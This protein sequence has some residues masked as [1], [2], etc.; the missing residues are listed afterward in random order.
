MT[1][2]REQFEK[3]FPVPDDVEWWHD[4]HNCYVIVDA[5]MSPKATR[6]D[7]HPDA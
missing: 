1:T 2:L 5:I 3:L 6:D 4:S 7:S